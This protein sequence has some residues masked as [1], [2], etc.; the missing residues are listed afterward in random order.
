MQIKLFMTVLFAQLEIWKQPNCSGLG[1]VSI[2]HG[3][4]YQLSGI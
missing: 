2:E 4:L 1:Q 3:I